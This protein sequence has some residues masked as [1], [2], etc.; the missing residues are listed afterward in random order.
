[1]KNKNDLLQTEFIQKFREQAALA[2]VNIPSI[3]DAKVL[4]DAFLAT[5][6]LGLR[7]R[8]IVHFHNFGKFMVVHRG[9]KVGRNPIKNT[10]MILP[11]HDTIVFKKS[12]HL[13]KQVLKSDADLSLKQ[14]Y[15]K[16]RIVSSKKRKGKRPYHKRKK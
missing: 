11:E 5:I 1:M 16:K 12:D 6:K 4:V 3:S 2:G 13:D 7:D 15:V 10:M 14:R 8:R 9:E